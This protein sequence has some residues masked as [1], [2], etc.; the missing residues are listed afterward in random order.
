MILLIW[1]HWRIPI[2][3]R[4]TTTA[5]APARLSTTGAPV[6]VCGCRDGN[7]ASPRGARIFYEPALLAL[8]GEDA[9]AHLSYASSNACQALV[10]G[11]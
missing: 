5:T 2:S 10:S 4:A 7:V 11:K 1:H 9:S 3:D 6:N 8:D